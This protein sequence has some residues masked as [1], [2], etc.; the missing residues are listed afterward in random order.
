MNVQVRYLNPAGNITAIVTTPLAT[1]KRAGLSQAIMAQGRAEQ[2]GFSVEPR[3]GGQCR[4]EM[5]GGEFCGN[6]VRAYGLLKGQE[7]GL[8]KIL[9]EI[10]GA[11]QPVAVTTNA[12]QQSAYADMPIPLS[13]DTLELGGQVCPLVRCQGICHLLARQVAPSVSF[14][15]SAAPALWALKQE[16]WGIMFL[17]GNRLTPVVYV[18]S[19]DSL[20]WESSCGSGSVAAGWYLAN[21]TGDAAQFVFQEPGG[22]IEVDVDPIS[23]RCI[24]GGPVEL[25]MRETFFWNG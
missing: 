8:N 5:M 12:S 13:V 17:E 18:T 21:I 11:P 4:L 22:V 7:L 2:V 23:A 25:G 24:M 20:V 10:S 3:N 15:S 16:A 14:V 6:A 1:E 9:V 19:T